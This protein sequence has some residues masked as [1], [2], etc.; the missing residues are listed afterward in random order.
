MKILTLIILMAC[1][2]F[3]KNDFNCFINF[4]DA[5]KIKILENAKKADFSRYHNCILELSSDDDLIVKA[6]Q[7]VCFNEV[8]KK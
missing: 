2:S 5:D 3:A 1:N 6:D 4:L 7:L 8:F